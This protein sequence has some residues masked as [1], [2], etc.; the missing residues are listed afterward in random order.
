MFSYRFF[1]LRRKERYKNTSVAGQPLWVS[2]RGWAVVNGTPKLRCHHQETPRAGD[3][4]ALLAHRD[5]R[6]HSLFPGFPV[7]V[8]TAVSVCTTWVCVLSPVTVNV[9]DPTGVEELVFT[10][11]VDEPVAG[12]WLQDTVVPVGRPVTERPT[13]SAN[14]LVPLI[15]TL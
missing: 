4:G 1:G 14:P 9:K 3:P 11:S 7:K 12:F 6:V 8:R 5:N 15:V 10:V 2:A 13:G